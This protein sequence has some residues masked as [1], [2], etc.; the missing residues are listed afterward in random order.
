MKLNL[1][2]PIVFFDLETTGTNINT[3]RI[4]SLPKNYKYSSYNAIMNGK[5]QAEILKS[6]F[7]ENFY[8]MYAEADTEENGNFIEEDLQNNI[9][10]KKDVEDMINEFCN[11]KGTTMK[12]IKQSNKLIIELKEHLMLY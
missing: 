12:Q 5:M 7:G 6:V 4:V 11:K 8:Y 1:K 3:D 10:D 2:N 9:I